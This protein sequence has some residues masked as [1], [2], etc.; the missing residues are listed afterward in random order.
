MI[1]AVLP[2]VAAAAAAAAPVEATPAWEWAVFGVVILAML[3]LD[4]I[5]FER[6]PHARQLKEAVIWSIVWVA[7]ALAF[8]VAVYFWKGPERALEFTTAYILE[9]AL[10][11]D[12]LFIFLVLFSFFGVDERFR[13]R[14]LFWGILGAFVMRGILIVAGVELVH[15]FAWILYIFGGVLVVTGGKLLVMSDDSYEPSKTIAYRLARRIIPMSTHYH[16]H[17]FFV[18]ENGRRL[19]TPLFLV[20]V[21]VEATDLVFAVDSIPACIAISQ[22]TFVVLT[23]NIFAILGLRAL[24]FVLA[25]LMKGLRF[26]KPGLAIVLIFIGFKMVLAEARK[27]ALLPEVLGSVAYIPVGASLGII[28]GILALAIIASLLFP[29]RDEKKPEALEKHADWIEGVEPGKEAAGGSDAAAA[30]PT[31]ATPKPDTPAPGPATAEGA[32]PTDR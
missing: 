25:G 9:K 16:E 23:S 29:K 31:E 1:H 18:I 32:P 13:P 5:I 17:R 27:D 7:L 28:G 24:Y 21:M 12:N 11:V 14:V 19:A 20:L 8:N 2:A 10:S 15:R 6:K 3:L 22:D 26:L 30:G 4:L